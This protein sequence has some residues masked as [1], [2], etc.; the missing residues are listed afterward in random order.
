MRNYLD[1]LNIHRSTDPAEKL[2]R[3]EAAEAELD[4]EYGADMTSVLTSNTRYMHYQR[5]HLQYEAMATALSRGISQR[6]TNSWSKRLVE[7]EPSAKE[8]PD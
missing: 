1:L 6:D 7:F 5:L 3:V 8:L 4:E 2:A